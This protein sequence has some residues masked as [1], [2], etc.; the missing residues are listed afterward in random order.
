MSSLVEVQTRTADSVKPKHRRRLL[1]RWL[2]RSAL[3]LC[4]IVFVGAIVKAWL[5][6]PLSVELVEVDRGVLRAT[7]DE[8]GRTQTSDRFVVSAPVS[9]QLLRIP[10]HSGDRVAA[11]AV[12]ARIVPTSSP[13]LDVRSTREAQ[14]RVAAARAGASRA[15]AELS[16]ARALFDHAD[17]ELAREQKMFD[18]G[19]TPRTALDN[20]LLVH[21]TATADVNAA[22]FAVTSADFDFELA[23]AALDT[24][25]NGTPVP[26]EVRAPSAGKILK[27]L[28]QSAQVVSAG[29]PLVEVGDPAALEVVVDV[30]TRDAVRITAGDRA[31]VRGWGGDPVDAVVRRV[32]PAAFTRLSALGVDEQRVNVILDVHAPPEAWTRMGDGYRVEAQITVWQQDDVIKLPAAALFRREGAWAVF[33]E[34]EGVASIRTVAL[35]QRSAREAQIL[36][37][38]DAGERVVIHPS[39]ALRDGAKIRQFGAE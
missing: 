5:P 28:Q 29:A 3:L 38:V 31:S 34:Q 2:K 6:Q 24:L 16:R 26:F 8:D 1:V 35:G 9:G 19:V 27:V 7:V 39:D 13:L 20:A 11:G 37:G 30:L 14:A 21:E 25:A 15:R 22:R 18:A 36:S 33:V 23:R 10:H 17:R 12:I 4:A 32:E